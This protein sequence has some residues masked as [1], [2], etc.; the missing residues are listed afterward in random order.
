MTSQYLDF[1]EK[2]MDVSAVK[3]KTIADNISNYNTPNF[4]ASIV[5]F[6][7]MFQNELNGNGELSLKSTDT[8]HIKSFDDQDGISIEKDYTTKER[9]DGNNVDLNA[10]MVDMIKNNF[11]SDLTVQA[12]NKEFSLQKIAI[13]K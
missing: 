12:I 2:V 3:R 10:E 7:K 8:K 5:D 13:G 4:K 1:I 9:E 11:L 6:E